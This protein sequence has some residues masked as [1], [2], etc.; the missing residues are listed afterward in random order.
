V[1]G[2]KDEVAAEHVEAISGPSFS[3]ETTLSLGRWRG[4]SRRR[5]TAVVEGM[6]RSV[7]KQQRA[8]QSACA[9]AALRVLQHI[10][11]AEYDVIADLAA[12][13]R[14]TVDAPRRTEEPSVFE[15]AS[16]RD[17]FRKPARPV[18]G[19]FRLDLAFGTNRH[20]IEIICN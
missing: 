8:P 4:R 3:W 13:R 5:I 16:D 1:R 11:P 14:R 17:H 7:R 20:M 9:W 2:R 10:R 15:R 18:A 19:V 12:L 6:S